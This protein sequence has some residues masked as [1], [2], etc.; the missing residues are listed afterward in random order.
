LTER[1]ISFTAGD[2]SELQVKSRFAGWAGALF[3]NVNALRFSSKDSTLITSS[4][5]AP[6]ADGG[7]GRRASSFTRLTRSLID[8]A[9]TRAGLEEAI[10]RVDN[11]ATK[12]WTNEFD[13]PGWPEL[14]ADGEVRLRN[15]I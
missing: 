5:S 12:Y 8:A 2:R 7:I 14:L 15:E 10:G 1:A 3:S 9:P 13:D 11:I 4:T 6:S